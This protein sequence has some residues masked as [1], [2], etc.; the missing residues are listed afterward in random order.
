M[1]L[2]EG[3]DVP[4]KRG[5]GVLIPHGH[6]VVGGGHQRQRDQRIVTALNR[7]PR[8]PMEPARPDSCADSPESSRGAQYR[9][10]WIP[11]LKESWCATASPAPT[12]APRRARCPLVELAWTSGAVDPGGISSSSVACPA[13]LVEVSRPPELSRF[14]CGVVDSPA[15][16][17]ESAPASVSESGAVDGPGG[18]ASASAA[19]PVAVAVAP[20]APASGEPSADGALEESVPVSARATLSPCPVVTSTPTP[21]ATASAPTRPM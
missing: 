11:R 1:D 8:G 7:V 3:A 2:T 12:R 13:S 20:P 14:I 19:V 5:K 10:A 15:V 17:G 9:S 16:V 18:G 6:R 4:G 21:S